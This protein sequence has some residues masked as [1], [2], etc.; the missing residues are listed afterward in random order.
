MVP[1]ETGLVTDPKDSAANGYVWET[2]YPETTYSGDICSL[3]I[4]QEDSFL[5]LNNIIFGEVWRR[6][7]QS[8]MVW[9]M[10]AIEDIAN[11]ASYTNIRMYQANVMVQ[12]L[13]FLVDLIRDINCGGET[14]SWEEMLHMT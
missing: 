8:N 9:P 7:G 1:H 2:V 13:S 14:G 5:L 10:Y 12:I 6:S 4:K 3:E 11:S